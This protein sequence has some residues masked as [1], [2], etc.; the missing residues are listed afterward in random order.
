[1]ETAERIPQINTEARR[2]ITQISI[3]MRRIGPYQR[4]LF[5]GGYTDIAQVDG[6]LK[7][8]KDVLTRLHK[9]LEEIFFFKTEPID[10][11]LDNHF[12]EC[13]TKVKQVREKKRQYINDYITITEELK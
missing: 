1:M 9:A 3:P 2:S 5:Q 12:P 6:D 4:E 8:I 11:I 10:K 7:H 13:K